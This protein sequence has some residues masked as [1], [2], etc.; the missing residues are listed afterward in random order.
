MKKYSLYESKYKFSKSDCKL[1]MYMNYELN[2]K[3]NLRGFFIS[4]FSCLIYKLDTHT[5]QVT[6]SNRFLSST[7]SLSKGFQVK[8]VV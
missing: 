8:Y 1:N 4:T 5:K 2:M 3:S 6:R 7:A